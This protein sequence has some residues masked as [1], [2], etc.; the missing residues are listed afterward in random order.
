MNYGTWYLVV[1]SEALP[2]KRLSPVGFAHSSEYIMQHFV[3][4]AS[5]SL[6]LCDY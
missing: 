3:T 4:V 2:L 5:R 1:I 6:F